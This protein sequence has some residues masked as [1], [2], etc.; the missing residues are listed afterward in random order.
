MERNKPSLRQRMA[1]TSVKGLQKV[2][3]KKGYK[4]MEKIGT[5]HRAFIDEIQ[6]KCANIIELEPENQQASIVATVCANIIQGFDT[7]KEMNIVIEMIQTAV[8]EYW[9]MEDIPQKGGNGAFK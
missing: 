9:K 2:A 5:K 6:N 3:V 7:K 4:N 1:L 8:D